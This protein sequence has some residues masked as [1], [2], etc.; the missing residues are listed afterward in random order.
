VDSTYYV[1]HQKI[2]P[3]NDNH[4]ATITGD[5]YPL[6]HSITLQSRRFTERFKRSSSDLQQETPTGKTEKEL[7]GSERKPGAPGGATTVGVRTIAKKCNSR[8]FRRQLEVPHRPSSG[9][10]TLREYAYD[11]SNKRMCD[12]AVVTIYNS[13]RTGEIAHRTGFSVCTNRVKL[14]HRSVEEN[15]GYDPRG[16]APLFASG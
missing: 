1:T 4:G 7:S 9:C 5:T 16:I 2:G 12:S 6:N 14:F 13:R 3:Q 10:R 11:V 15:L 8:A